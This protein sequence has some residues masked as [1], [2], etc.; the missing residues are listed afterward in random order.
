MLA[1][2]VVA[3]SAIDDSVGAVALVVDVDGL[4]STVRRRASSRR[5][6]VDEVDEL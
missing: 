2:V 6:S 3:V 5:S 4:S 1:A